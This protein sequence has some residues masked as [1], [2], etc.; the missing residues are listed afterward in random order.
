MS[1]DNVRHAAFITGELVNCNSTSE[2]TR[3]DND[4]YSGIDYDDG[5]G[6]MFYNMVDI[7]EGDV[8]FYCI[9]DDPW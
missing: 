3:M 8:A 1:L 2:E 6:N 4:T 7:D 9:R 5:N